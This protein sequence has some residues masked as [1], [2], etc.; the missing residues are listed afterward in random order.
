MKTVYNITKQL[1][2]KYN[3]KS[4]ETIKAKDG[5]LLTTEKE[6]AER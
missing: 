6:V 2:G 5:K 1:S 3:K 4:G